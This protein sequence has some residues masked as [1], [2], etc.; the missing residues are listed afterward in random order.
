[1][2]CR[3]W[4]ITY[5]NPTGVDE[6]VN[7]VE[8]CEELKNYSMQV[9][10]GEEGTPH[11]Q[12]YFGF[13]TPKRR[14]FINNLLGTNEY[15][16]EISEDPY[17]SWL[18]CKKPITRILGP[19]HSEWDAHHQGERTDLEKATAIV[20]TGGALEVAKKFPTLFVKFNKGFFELEKA[21]NTDDEVERK[22]RVMFFYGK[23]GTGKTHDALALGASFVEKHGLFYQWE[24]ISNARVFDEADEHVWRR[25]EILRICDRYPIMLNIKGGQKIWNPEI[26]IFTSN[27]PP[28]TWLPLIDGALRRRVTEVRHYK[29]FGEYTVETL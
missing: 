12:I 26:V 13:R 25:Q 11:F 15:H 19:W 5:N 28:A 1:M 29:D 27:D 20:K 23:T 21:L 16:A 24:S 10:K 17:K 22:K 18:Y 7:R 6:I 2:Q 8:D 4:C 9:E 3:H 14:P